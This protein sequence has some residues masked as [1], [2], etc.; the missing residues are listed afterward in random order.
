MENVDPW[1]V[2]ILHP[3]NGDQSTTLTSLLGYEHKLGLE[4]LV[5]T[6]LVRRGHQEN[7]SYAVVKKEWEMFIVEHDLQEIMEGINQ[8]SVVRNKIQFINYGRRAKLRHRPIDQFGIAA[9]KKRQL[10]I[11]DLQQKFH[12]QVSKVVVAARTYG[13]SQSADDESAEYDGSDVEEPEEKPEVIPGTTIFTLNRLNFPVLSPLLGEN[14]RLKEWD[15]QAMLRELITHFGKNRKVDWQHSNGKKARAVI[16]PQVKDKASFMREAWNDRW[17]E[18]ILE[19][20]TGLSENLEIE[21]AAEWLI[22]YLGKKY[23]TSFVLALEALGLPLVQRM[24]EASTEAMWCDANINV[25]QQRILRKHLKFHFGKR[26]FL[27]QTQLKV[28]REMYQV[29]TMY[30]SYKY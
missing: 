23:D 5:G 13:K 28:N 11:I 20:L 8:T 14:Y 25:V 6:G 7:P 19:H 1:W 26:I 10:Y 16:I 2:S 22:T 4:F 12:R 3:V 24:D 9:L 30:G 27:P 29:E 17:L 15:L 18:S 21:N